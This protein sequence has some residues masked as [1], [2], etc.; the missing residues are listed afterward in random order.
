MSS[1]FH[2]VTI[3]QANYGGHY[4]EAFAGQPR[5]INPLL[6]YSSSADRGLTKLVFAGLFDYDNEGV[7]R[8]DIAERFEVSEDLKEYTV[9]LHKDVKWHDSENLTADDVIFTIDMVKNI[10]YGAVGVSNDIRLAWHDVKIEKIDDHSIKFILNEEDNTFLHNLTLGLLPK[11]IWESVSPE[12]FQLSQYNQEPIGAGP[13]EFVN[14]DINTEDDLISSYT[15]RSN[16]NYHK[17]VPFITKFSINF[18]PTRGEAVE[19]F[20]NG[21]VS[22]VIVE[23]EE[24]ISALG[25]IAQQKSIESPHYFAIFFNQ[26]KSIPLAFDEVREALMLSTDRDAIIKDIFNE[27][28]ASA[29]YS[30]FVENMIGFDENLQQSSVDVAGANA[31]LD[32]KGWERDEDGIRKKDDTRLEFTLQVSQSHEQLKRVATSLKEQWKNIGIEMHIEEHEGEYLSMNI[33]KPRDY[34]AILYGHQMR[35]DD[36][37]LLPLWHSRE[38][39]DPGVNYAMFKDEEMNSA[40]VDTL[41]KNNDDERVELYKKQQERLK[42]EIPAIFLFAQNLSFMYSDNIKN[43]NVNRVNTSYD[44][45]ADVNKWYIKEKRIKKE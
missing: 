44:R 3:P 21:E 28:N 12:Q 26:S 45:Y 27:Q 4:K 15:L 11:H 7:L 35:F 22:A 17:D 10:E 13:Y 2:F 30:P 42:N 20:R 34:D 37:N 14:V 6:A 33:I 38:K 9:F 24:H 23:K 5:F 19:A 31:V 40:L 8:P 1:I 25:E 43:V 41:K 18:Y 29:R 39:D 36:P 32:E 16:E